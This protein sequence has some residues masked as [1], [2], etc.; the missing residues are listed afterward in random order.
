MRTRLAPTPSGLLHPG[1]GLSFIVTW[2]LA[3]AAGGEVLLRIDDLD[4][5]RCRP[6]YVED[7]FATLDWVGLDYDQG[8]TGVEDFFNNFSQHKRLDLYADALRR[9]RQEGHLYACSCSRRKILEDSPS[10]IYPGTCRHRGLSFERAPSAWRVR[11]PEPT[12]VTFQEWKAGNR[13]FDLSGEMGDFVVRQKDG[14]PAYQIASLV[15]DVHFNIDFIVRGEDLLPSTGAQVFLADVLNE[16]PFTLATFWHHALVTDQEGGKLSKSKG[17]G[18]LQEWRRA[19]HSP[20]V[21]FRQA[22]EWLGLPPADAGSLTDLVG[23]LR[24]Q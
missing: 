14:F 4:K 13:Q 5:A 11:V 12:T 23:L 3:R 22:A 6:E 1:N 7:V 16:Q 18:S 10:G 17:A 19:G 9:L 24:K 21:L 8:P 2:C 20:Q 15:D